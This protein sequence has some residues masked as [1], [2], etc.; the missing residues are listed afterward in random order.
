MYACAREA[1]P[2]AMTCPDGTRHAIGTISV[3]F[4]TITHKWN[5]PGASEIFLFYR[6]WL[7]NLSSNLSLS[8]SHKFL[9]ELMETG[10]QEILHRRSLKLHSKWYSIH[11]ITKANS[12]TGDWK[13]NLFQQNKKWIIILHL[14]FEY[15]IFVRVFEY[16]SVSLPNHEIKL[17]KKTKFY[18]YNL[19]DARRLVSRSHYSRTLATLVQILLF[20]SNL[21]IT[22]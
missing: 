8:H 6:H 2:F 7:S 10:S 1:H 21:N 9:R 4:E 15:D 19:I 13:P 14:L 3:H 12:S 22:Y 11:R 5:S 18:I 17:T 20:W 16:E